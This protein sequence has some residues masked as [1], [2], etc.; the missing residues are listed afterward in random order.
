MM[1]RTME[2]RLTYTVAEL[3]LDEGNGERVL[4]AFLAIAPE[5][6]P[7]VSQ[8]VVRGTLDVTIAIDAKALE[9]PMGAGADLPARDGRGR[10][11]EL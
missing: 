6:G 8:N 11:P 5:A 10:S 7:V 4:D 2:H 3:G 9:E 1:G